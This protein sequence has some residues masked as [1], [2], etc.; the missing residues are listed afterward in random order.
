MVANSTTG[1]INGNESF[2]F[3]ADFTWQVVGPSNPSI[4]PLPIGLL[5]GPVQLVLGDT[6]AYWAHAARPFPSTGGGAAALQTYKEKSFTAGE[7]LAWLGPK[8]LD[9]GEV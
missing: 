8:N 5:M 2:N 9:P 3:V 7:V 1:L 4:P 6:N